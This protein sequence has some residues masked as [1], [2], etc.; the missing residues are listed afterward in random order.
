MHEGAVKYTDAWPRSSHC[1][2]PERRPWPGRCCCPARRPRRPRSLS[3]A[4]TSSTSARYAASPAPPPTRLCFEAMESEKI[5]HV[6]YLG[7][8]AA[9]Q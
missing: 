5:D 7:G 4:G 2:C 6:I 1:C 8:G 3:R 9:T